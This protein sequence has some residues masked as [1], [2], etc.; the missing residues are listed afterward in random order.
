[1]LQATLHDWHVLSTTASVPWLRQVID[2]S[3][4]PDGADDEVVMVDVLVNTSPVSVSPDV[5]ADWV[6][7]CARAF[8]LTSVERQADA[9]IEGVTCW[10]APDGTARSS[11]PQRHVHYAPKGFDW[12]FGGSGPADLALN[13]LALFLPLAVEATGVALRDGSSVSEAAWALHQAFKYDLIATLPRAGGH[14]S[15]KTIRAWITAHPVV[16][17]DPLFSPLEHL[18]G[19][20]PLALGL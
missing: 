19:G 5:V 7:D 3:L 2:R 20:P 11:I 14:I 18:D 13:V 15:T 4:P 17:A 16:G 1:M 10:R 6:V 8:G 12:G 9:L